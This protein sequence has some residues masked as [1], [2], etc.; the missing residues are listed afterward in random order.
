MNIEKLKKLIISP[1]RLGRI[2][3]FLRFLVLSLLFGGGEILYGLVQD[4]ALRHKNNYLYLKLFVDCIVLPP[5]FIIWI[6]ALISVFVARLHDM[7]KGAIWLSVVIPT[8]AKIPLVGPVL[9]LLFLTLWPGTKGA[10]RFGEQPGVLKRQSEILPREIMH[11]DALNTKA[12]ANEP[13]N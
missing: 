1:A 10:N 4:I 9:I 7:N 11:I 13:G 12:T 8:V 3:Y 6:I 2:D 5:V